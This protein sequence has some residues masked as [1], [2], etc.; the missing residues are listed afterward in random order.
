MKFENTQANGERTVKQQ[1]KNPVILSRTSETKKRAGN[2][3]ERKEAG[4]FYCNSCVYKRPR[5]LSLSLLLFIIQFLILR[6][7]VYTAE[8]AKCSQH[9]GA[10][11]W[12]KHENRT[13]ELIYF[14]N[15]RREKG[16]SLKMLTA[17]TRE[18][19]W[20]QE[21]NEDWFNLVCRVY[22]FIY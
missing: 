5:L 18:L 2:E 19:K 10:L 21:R 15:R 14:W 13:R 17:V 11:V 3:R 22:F 16:T 9:S 4:R 1:R 6:R 20:I 7:Q 8:S 12:E